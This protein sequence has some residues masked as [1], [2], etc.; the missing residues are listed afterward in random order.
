MNLL[1]NS[2]F[3]A[4]SALLFNW[5]F[6]FRIKLP[7]FFAAEVNFWWIFH[8]RKSHQHSSERIYCS[9]KVIHSQNCAIHTEIEQ[10]MQFTSRS[11]T[12]C[13][14]LRFITSQ[15]FMQKQRVFRLKEILHVWHRTLSWHRNCIWRLFKWI[16]LLLPQDENFYGC[17]SNFLYKF[18][19]PC[20]S[21]CAKIE[22]WIQQY[23]KYVKSVKFRLWIATN[24]LA[25]FNYSSVPRL[26]SAL[27][28]IHLGTS[29]KN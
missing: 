14:W 9:M 20:R 28:F 19:F 25:R 4:A 13:R 22:N 11:L 6:P 10:E 7:L 29:V 15:N 12:C 1:S 21:F 18:N 2:F 8:L 16:F 17:I 5:I 26:I 23:G 27:N 24:S 3:I